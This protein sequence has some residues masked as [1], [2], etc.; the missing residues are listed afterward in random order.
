MVHRMIAAGLFPPPDYAH[1][2]VIEAGERLAFMAG[3]VPLDGDGGLVGAGDHVAQTRQV[4]ANLR[5]A[6]EAVGSDLS[7]VLSTTVYVVADT[8]EALGR[9]WDVVRRSELS[10]GPHASTLL[11]VSCLGYT[12]QL[13]EITA[14]AAVP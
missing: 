3:A 10:A 1:A 12:G 11:G 14:I 5:T 9:V 8:P 4:I 13:V 2:A 6:L 7:R